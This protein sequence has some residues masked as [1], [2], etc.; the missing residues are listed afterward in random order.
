MSEIRRRPSQEIVQRDHCVAFTQN[1]IAKVR[2]NESGGAGRDYTQ[3]PS[4]P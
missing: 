3:S 1:A 4:S 2:P